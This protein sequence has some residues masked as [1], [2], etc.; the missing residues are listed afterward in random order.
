MRRAILIF[1]IAAPI[2]AIVVWRT[3]PLAAVGVVF[4]SHML[5]LYPTLR[6][7]AQWLGPVITSFDTA[8]KEVWL[9]IDDGPTEDTREILDAFDARG[10]KATFFCKGTLAEQRPEL[11]REMMA[12]GHTVAN[13]SYSHPSGS[14][15]CLPPARIATQIEKANDVLRRTTGHEARLFRAPIGHKNPA[16]HPILDRNDMRLIGWSARAF[17]TQMTDVDG[18]AR[19][20]LKDVKPGSIILMHQGRAHSPRALM[21]VVDDLV[22]LGYRF[23]VPDDSRLKTNR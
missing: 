8:E 2:I 11:I 9:T 4:I 10:V 19:R 7:N 14:F 16:V 17:D 18:I 22:A 6:P 5:V 23:V 12:R 21:R 13:H 20:L 15:W 1:L 3:S